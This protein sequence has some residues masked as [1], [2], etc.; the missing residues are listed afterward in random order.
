MQSELSGI[1]SY[2]RPDVESLFMTSFSLGLHPSISL[3][4]SLIFNCS[5][6]SPRFPKSN[7]TQPPFPPLSTL[8]VSTH[9]TGIPPEQPL[10]TGDQ[11]IPF[12]VGERGIA[13]QVCSR[14]VL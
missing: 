12:I 8:V 7:F 9:Q 11:G 10:P 13:D 5:R 14:G 3:H 2:M 6:F 1:E 4:L